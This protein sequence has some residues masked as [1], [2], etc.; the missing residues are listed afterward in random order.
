MKKSLRKGKMELN[1]K[2]RKSL[3]T[4]IV[5]SDEDIMFD[6]TE[7]VSEES[8]RGAVAFEDQKKEVAD[9]IICVASGLAKSVSLRYN[10]EVIMLPPWGKLNLIKRFVGGLPAGVYVCS[11]K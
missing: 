6:G 3:P 5:L 10:G 1:K 9:E 7:V 4:G 8:V 2:K 11:K